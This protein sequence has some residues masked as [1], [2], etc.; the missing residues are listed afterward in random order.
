[1]ISLLILKALAIAVITVGPCPGLAPGDPALGCA[2]PPNRIYLV[3]TPITLRTRN[4]ELGHLI[5]YNFLTNADRGTFSYL[6]HERRAWDAPGNSPHEQFA[7]AVS[8]CARSA[9]FPDGYSGYGYTPSTA[10][11]RRICRWLTRVAQRV[12]T[13]G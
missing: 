8:M 2:V 7:E 9:R 11:H 4:H 12:V 13:A 10:Q 5:D 1:M 3:E 6:I